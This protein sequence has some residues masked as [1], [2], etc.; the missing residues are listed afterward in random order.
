MSFTVDSR[1]TESS[2]FLKDWPLCQVFLKNNADYPWFILVPKKYQV[3]DLDQLDTQEQQQLMQEITKISHVI[4]EIFKPEKLNVATLGNIV[5][6][7][8]IHLVARFQTDPL[9]PQGVWQT[10]LSAPTYAT[11]DLEN[12]LRKILPLL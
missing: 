8:H 6:Q 11:E 4:R 1:I 2:I 7:L 9:W 5:P 3:Q 12:L 10:A